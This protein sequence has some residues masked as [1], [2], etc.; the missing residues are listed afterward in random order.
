MFC[1]SNFR[2]EEQHCSMNTLR[3]HVCQAI[4]DELQNEIN[5]YD[6]SD[7]E[8][9]EICTRLWERFYSACEQYHMKASQPIGLLVLENLNA[10]CIIKKTTFS[11]LRPCEELEHFML[12][13][14][15]ED[16]NSLEQFQFVPQEDLNSDV[17]SLMGLLAKLEK[18]L[19]DDIKIDFDRKLYQ[20]EQ[21]NTL[22]EKIVNEWFLK[23]E[24]H[25]HLP[26][27]MSNII[28]R[29]LQR[30]KDLPKVVSLL[31]TVLYNHNDEE[32]SGRDRD[33][34]DDDNMKTEMSIAN[35]FG[36][37]IGISMLSETVRQVTL[38]RYALCRNL[39]LLNAIVN[40]LQLLPVNTMESLR[41]QLMPNVVDC[42]LSY[43][44]MVWIAETPINVSNTS[45]TFQASI[46][47][48][49]VP[50]FN[51]VMNWMHQ[52]QQYGQNQLYPA[53]TFSSNQD[54][55]NIASLL[56]M[57]LNSR[58]LA[59]SL[60]HF[61]QRTNF[62]FDNYDWQNTLLPLV[63]FISQQIWSISSEFN[64]GEWLFST[65]Q[66]VLIEDYVRLS[67][68]WCESNLYSRQFML[69]VTL[70]DSGNISKAFDLFLQ[71][72]KGV[73]EDQ[74]LTSKILGDSNLLNENAILSG[75]FNVKDAAVKK[76]LLRLINPCMAEYFLR[77]IQLFEQHNAL[78]YII[79]IAQVAIGL[80]DTKNVE[81]NQLLPMFQSIVFNNH[82]QLEHYAKA[83]H[84]LIYNADAAR[85]KDCLR[86]L[87]ITLFN[88]KR[89][90]L[91]ANFP[92]IGL[93]AEFENIVES[94]A[95][96][97]SIEN[98]EV[99]DFLYAY[100]LNNGNMRKGKEKVT[101]F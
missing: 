21:P 95:R 94:R 58:G 2:F 52:Q 5:T 16:L 63:S 79:A 42:L 81:N 59:I 18:W 43:Y 23:S 10:V 98:N 57:F 97:Q 33:N 8:Y 50:R 60:A 53:V 27:N 64:F 82:L 34:L 69:A 75:D 100:H 89:L 99:Y 28:Q 92:Y 73:V 93:E 46:Q 12:V 39:L 87:V 44:V 6:V 56:K 80:L 30:V 83:Y 7:E 29:Q 45:P 19:P 71:A 68:N 31:L 41:S 76:E 35:L 86:Q 78:D 88:R 72:A 49:N 77:V 101:D 91:L 24:C 85:R 84:S 9:L 13:G 96:T 40:T 1:R 54:Q 38:I 66:H 15:N 22:I 62:V 90:D 14:E 48:L 36:S 70:L 55:W 37:Q 3:D 67:N 20:L 11:M 47:K 61:M 4:E 51:M 17:I 65:G 32:Y 74:F 26:K 25:Q